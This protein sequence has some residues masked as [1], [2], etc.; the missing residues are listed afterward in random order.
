VLGSVTTYLFPRN[1]KTPKPQLIIKM[2]GIRKNMSKTIY[3]DQNK[4]DLM[5]SKLI[6]G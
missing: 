5:I 4:Q 6:E 1:P 2:S 3:F